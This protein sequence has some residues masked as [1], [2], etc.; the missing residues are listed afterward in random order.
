[1]TCGIYAIEN[2]G[3]GHVYI[4]RSTNVSKRIQHHF[5]K[6]ENN[7]HNNPHMQ[8]SYDKYGRALFIWRLLLLCRPQDLAMYERLS[9]K[10]FDSGNRVRGFNLMAV[11][12]D[13][14]HYV[15]NAE[16][17]AKS[18]EYNRQRW[19]DP[20]Y[21]ATRS[22][23]QRETIRKQWEDPAFRELRRKAASDQWNDPDR[24]ARFAA[25]QSVSLKAAWQDPTIRERHRRSVVESWTDE[26]RKKSGAKIKSNWTDPVYRERVIS[27]RKGQSKRLWQDPAYRAKVKAGREA[28]RKRKV[29]SDGDD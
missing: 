22:K 10:G 14:E 9:I 28:A 6:L 5:W 23:Q 3:T 12:E 11:S 21:R 27:S 4:G 26:R 20:E 7:R 15:H 2:I 1:M 8:A 18:S 29:E 16:A 19:K 24:R 17:R 25:K 13:G